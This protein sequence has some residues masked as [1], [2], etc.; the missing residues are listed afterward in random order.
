MSDCI[1][2]P[3]VHNLI[4]FELLEQSPILTLKAAFVFAFPFPL[5][6]VL[7]SM[8]EF[9]GFLV[10]TINVLSVKLALPLDVLHPPLLLGIWPIERQQSITRD[11][12]HWPGWADQAMLS[13]KDLLLPGHL[14]HLVLPVHVDARICL[15]LE[16]K[17]MVL[18]WVAASSSTIQNY[19]VAR[20][21]RRVGG[22][23]VGVGA[24]YVQ[25]ISERHEHSVCMLDFGPVVNH[26]IDG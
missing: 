8:R 10:G 22:Q 20:L 2:L 16:H 18:L 25:D 4:I 12:C 7:S 3:I 11:R 23:D 9:S 19:I 14:K 17:V 15:L 21:D 5:L 1:E 6:F 26:L 24:R 13:A